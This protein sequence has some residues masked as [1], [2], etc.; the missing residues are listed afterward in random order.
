[1]R[2]R[3]THGT[4]RAGFFRPTTYYNV[5]VDVAFTHEE[6]AIIVQSNLSIYR[7]VQRTPHPEDVRGLSPQ[8]IRDIPYL[9]DLMVHS[10]LSGP[11]TYSFQSQA[12]ANAYQAQLSA[13][14]QLLKNNIN[15]GAR[16][17]EAIVWE[18]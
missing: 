8:Q 9:G 10:I 17:S 5:T 6:R 1:M 12:E 16:V 15:V 13:A 11:D 4:H 14:L 18:I 7:L 2:V 3:I